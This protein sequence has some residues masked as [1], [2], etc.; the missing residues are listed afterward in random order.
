MQASIPVVCA[1][2]ET[3]N[4][5]LCAQRGERMPHPGK[6]EFPGGK[7]EPMETPEAALVREIREEL[8]VTV[9]ILEPLPIREHSFPDG[10][11]IRL[12]PFRCTL[13]PGQKPRPREHAGLRWIRE[14]DLPCLDWVAADIPVWQDY[15]RHSP[16]NDSPVDGSFG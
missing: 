11:T 1:V 7:L 15:L 5:I 3:E 4:G 6:W 9:T 14:K 12:I 13:A 2:I 16:D 10:K 8:G